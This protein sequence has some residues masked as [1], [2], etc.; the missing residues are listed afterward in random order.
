MSEVPHGSAASHPVAAEVQAPDAVAIGPVRI[1]RLSRD[2]AIQRLLETIATRRRERIAFANAHGI[3]L[4]MDE[5]VFADTLSRFLVLNDGIGAEIGARVLAGKGFPDNLNGTDFIPALL[6]KAPAGTRLYLLGAKP[7]IVE[8]AAD[9]FAAN[10]ANIDVCG[11]RDGYFADK[12]EPAVAAG[13]NAA[14]P[15]ILLV[16]M[17]NPKQEFLI[18]RLF[19]HLDVPLAIGVG[20]LFDFTAGEVVRAPSL[21]RRTGLEWVFRFLQEPRRLGKRYTSGVIRYLWKIALLKLRG[22]GGA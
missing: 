5:P 22:R 4:A 10:H 19:D 20:A 18:D 3:L 13:I 7:E 16:A 9:R 6:D 15:D 1:V 12:D 14:R 2:A 11:W 21:L 8:R 17:G